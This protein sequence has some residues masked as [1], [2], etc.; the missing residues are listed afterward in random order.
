MLDLIAYQKKS[1]ETFPGEIGKLHIHKIIIRART[2]Q[3]KNESSIFLKFQ[4]KHG[5]VIASKFSKSF[6]CA[7]DLVVLGEFMKV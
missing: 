1:D 6:R 5:H 3:K 7:R 4:S 2:V